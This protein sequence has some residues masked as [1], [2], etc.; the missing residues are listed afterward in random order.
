[1]GDYY[2]VF[3]S[4]MSRPA[5]QKG[6]DLYAIRTGIPKFHQQGARFFMAESS[7]L[8]GAIGLGHYLTARLTWD[9]S[10][11]PVAFSVFCINSS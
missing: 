4:D 11:A 7:D 2:S 1:M 10:Q 5:S 3:L 9:S 6:T 8:W